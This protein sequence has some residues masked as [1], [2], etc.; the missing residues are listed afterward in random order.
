MPTPAT[1]R[2]PAPKSEDEWEDMVLDALRVRWRDPNA[3]RH[4]RRGQRQNGVDIY[5]RDMLKQE[6]VG[7]QV[8]NSETITELVIREEI[9][10]AE[11]F[12][13]PLQRY[14]LALSGPRDSDVEERVR[15]LSE[16]REAT[17][18]FPVEVLFFDDICQE[19]CARPDLV[20]KHWPG[21]SP[22][23]GLRI[24]DVGVEDETAPTTL[25]IKLR[26]TGGEVC[27]VKEARIDVLRVGI[28]DTLARRFRQQPVTGEYNVAF[29]PS[30][31]APYSI[32]VPV[33]QVVDPNDTDR[34]QLRLS[35]TSDF[36]WSFVRRTLVH[37][38]LTLVH[39]EDNATPT[40]VLLLFNVPPP[41]VI[42]GERG[43]R[44]EEYVRRARENTAI[45][46]TML[47]LPGQASPVIEKLRAS[48]KSERQRGQEPI[49]DE[50]R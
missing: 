7:A 41:R 45:L 13:P 21:W 24:V 2:W 33:S 16:S 46:E 8:K 17:D 5:G 1:G 36:N 38:M 28:L 22:G 6:R 35:Y 26:N 48:V 34:F 11:T 30:R 20:A 50:Y 10:K 42:L 12:I 3:R 37:A 23:R 9:S 18:R 40:P 47:A 49:P 15:L 29:D 19:I 14:F 39:D 25:D 44:D 32:V 27:F 4:G 31:P 43:V